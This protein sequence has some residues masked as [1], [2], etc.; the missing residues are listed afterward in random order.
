MKFTSKVALIDL[1]TFSRGF[2]STAS[3]A[4]SQQVQYNYWQ[5]T[6]RSDRCS[7]IKQSGNDG[8]KGAYMNSYILPWHIH[9]FTVYLV[10]ISLT[11]VYEAKNDCFLSVLY[12]ASHVFLLTRQK[13]YDTERWGLSTRKRNGCFVCHSFFIHTISHTLS[14]TRLSTAFF[15][16]FTRMVS[17]TVDMMLIHTAVFTFQ[18]MTQTFCKLH[19]SF[20]TNN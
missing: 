12:T 9:Y 17:A 8:D 3:G 10:V 2:I 5:E 18:N 13:H 1:N 15:M 6:D 16:Y 14:Y 4:S 11:P 19:F 20:E 7:M